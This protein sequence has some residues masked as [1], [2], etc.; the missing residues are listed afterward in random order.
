MHI[1]EELFKQARFKNKLKQYE[2][3]KSERKTVFMDIDDLTDIIDYYNYDGLVDDAEDVANYALTLYPGAIGPL[4]FKA[5]QALAEGEFDKAK[6][7]SDSI[8]DKSDLDYFYLCAEMLIA[9]R[10]TKEAENLFQK[11]YAETDI[12]EHYN[13]CLDVGALY[14]D[15]GYSDLALDWL[16]RTNDPE[17]IER[18]EL[19]ARIYCN[20]GEYEKATE[21]LE[22]LIDNNPFVSRHW[23]MLALIQLCNGEYPEC[24]SS[25]EYSLA[26]T[27]EN[28]DGLWCKAKALLSMNEPGEALKHYRRFLERMPENA[29]AEADMGTCYLQLADLDKARDMLERAEG[30]CDLG[31]NILL[32]QIYD[33]LAYTY[34]CLKQ[35][36]KAL[37]Y[38]GL[39]EQLENDSP[40]EER[41]PGRMVLEGHILLQNNQ[42]EKAL[43]IFDR[44]IELSD[45]SP[46]IMLKVCVSLYDQGEYETSIA[47]F[48]HL[49]TNMPQGWNLG[50][51]YMAGSLLRTHQF[52]EGVEYLKK[53]CQV[54]CTEAKL[55]FGDMFPADLPCDKYYD[56]I[57]NV[58]F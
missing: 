1:D 45:E 19:T 10:K 27:P 33:D 21:C 48:R 4:V 40:N 28:T 35:L 7:F 31:D 5:R 32:I 11:K 2:Q 58:K 13:F 57:K 50:F 6:E 39:A 38:L 22:K 53:A 24:K 44:A 43:S 20:M 18:L 16:E 17:D 46:D 56:Y 9:Q 47:Y 51:S 37:E 14:V 3:A 12:D 25:A 34:S 49:E 29:R 55:V 30:H 15:Y 23:N 36:D 52:K 41:D 26:I 42:K 8:E 54:N